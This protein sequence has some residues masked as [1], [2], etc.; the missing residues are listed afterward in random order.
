MLLR[1]LG[2]QPELV[3]VIDSHG[4]VLADSD[5]EVLTYLLT[6]HLPDADVNEDLNTSRGDTSSDVV[7]DDDDPAA[8]SI[9]PRQVTLDEH[10]DGVRARAVQI[11]RALGLPSDLVDVVAD[12]ARWHDL[13]KREERFQAMLHGGD[14]AVAAVA[15]D[16]LAK[17]GMD[18]ADRVAWI[19]ARQRSRLP[20]G[21]RHE[22]WSAALITAY[23]QDRP[24]PY[25]GDVDLLV[26]LVASHHGHSRPLLPLV[27]DPDPQPVTAVLDGITV[28]VPSERTV[29]LDGPSRFARLNDRYGRWGL[30]LLETVVRCADMTVSA[31]GS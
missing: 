21:A 1:W 24:T 6:G 28:S 25:P 11:A 4:S 14:P 10:L 17:S 2:G 22:A 8:S 16:A 31:E 13:G 3:E 18:P 19:R 23:L 26:H 5:P 9:S 20:E 12:A 29:L 27:G 15:V 7:R 30:A